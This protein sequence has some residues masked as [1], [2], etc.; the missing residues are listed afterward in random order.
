MEKGGAEFGDALVF[1]GFGHEGEAE[2]VVGEEIFGVEG[3]GA[4]A[5]TNGVVQAAGAAIAFAEAVERD[6]VIVVPDVALGDAL[7][8]AHAEE[9]A[10]HVVVELA[11]DLAVEVAELEVLLVFG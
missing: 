9:G 4:L 10:E 5:I 8:L 7:L 2:G 6:V 1:L 3:K 11:A